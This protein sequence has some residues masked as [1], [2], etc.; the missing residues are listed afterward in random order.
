M[1]DPPLQVIGLLARHLRPKAVSHRMK[2]IKFGSFRQDKEQLVKSY[3][4]A[5]HVVAPAHRVEE[6]HRTEE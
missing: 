1:R 3:R 4:R 6:I 2:S 5:V